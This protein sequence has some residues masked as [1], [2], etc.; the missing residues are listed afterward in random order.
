MNF[1]FKQNILGAYFWWW[2]DASSEFYAQG[3]AVKFP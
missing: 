2:A 1:R 3:D